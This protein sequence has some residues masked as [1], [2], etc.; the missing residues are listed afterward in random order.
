[1]REATTSRM[2]VADR[3]YG[4]FYEFYS[5]SPE[6]FGH[7]HLHSSVRT[8]LVYK[9]RIFSPSHDVIAEL[10]SIL[11]GLVSLLAIIQLLSIVY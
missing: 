7:Y 2:M 10:E 4:E 6:H 1:M 3:P 8:T 9:D 5:V 11:L